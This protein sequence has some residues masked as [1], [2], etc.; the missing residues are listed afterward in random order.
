MPCKEVEA[1]SLARAKR[2]GAIWVVFGNRREGRSIPRQRLVLLNTLAIGVQHNK[3]PPSG[4]TPC[5]SNIC[6][7]GA[8]DA[9]ILVAINSPAEAKVHRPN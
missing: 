6:T 9:C 8:I 5:R 1:L 3:R 7:G 4:R 2:I